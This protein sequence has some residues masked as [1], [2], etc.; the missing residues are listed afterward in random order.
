MGQTVALIP[1]HNEVL[2]VRKVVEKTM[3]HVD[4]VIV[5]DDGSDDG[6]TESLTGS[7]AE[8][9]RHAS[10]LGKGSRLVEGLD[11]AFSQGADF[12]ITL[13]ADQQHDPDD[14]PDFV[15]MFETNATALV[16]GDRSEDMKQMPKSRRRGIKFGNFFIGWGCG[17]RIKDA[18]CGM[19]LYPAT[20]WKKVRIPTKD[21]KKFKFETAALLYAAKAG[22]QFE[23]VPIAARYEGF[24]LRPSHFDPVR[25]FLRLFGLVTMFLVR[26]GF[27]LKGLLLMLGI[28]R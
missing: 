3:P 27:H 15:A 23:Y 21:T 8:V 24:I 16:L 12:V 1:A 4:R 9:I 14:I 6:T 18:Q 2:T 7:G 28:A 22:V 13:D 10:N 25:D 19:R 26:R 17:C 11:F 20:M 5:I